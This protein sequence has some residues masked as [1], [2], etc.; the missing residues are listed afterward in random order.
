MLKIFKGDHRPKNHKKARNLKIKFFVE[1]F[2]LLQLRKS[3]M[4]ATQL[5]GLSNRQ[6]QIDSQFLNLKRQ[7]ALVQSAIGVKS[8]QVDDAKGMETSYLFLT[9]P[10]HHN[11]HCKN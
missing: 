3:E 1:T 10:V 5:E 7:F 2:R 9:L 11:T 4:N 6:Q 8:S